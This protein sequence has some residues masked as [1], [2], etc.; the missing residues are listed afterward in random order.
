MSAQAP[1]PLNARI[2]A[3]REGIERAARHAGREP[4]KVTLLAVAKRK[5]AT[6]LVA[7]VRAGLSEI[8]EN[9]VQEALSK[10]PEVRQQLGTAASPRWHF[11]GRLQRNKARQVVEHFDVLHTLDRASLGDALERRAAESGRR[12]DV[13]LQADLCGEPQKG[14]AA[15]E[16]LPELLEA[17]LH[18]SH[19]Q[20]RGLMTLP[21][22]APNPEDSRPVFARLRALRDEL[23][24]LPGGASLDELSMGMSA[25]FEVAIQEGATIIRVGSAIFGPRDQPDPGRAT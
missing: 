6:E 10:M 8:A 13:L 17:S 12:L 23:R 24:A 14:G 19:L 22:A 9:Y 3:V 11:V 5:T 18:W 25:D 20:V 7:G 2:Q 15:P 16:T 4:D 21:A 1:N